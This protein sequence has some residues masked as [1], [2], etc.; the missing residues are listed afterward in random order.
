MLVEYTN[1]SNSQK[2]FLD[3]FMV[4]SQVCIKCFRGACHQY[5]INH[6]EGVRIRMNDRENTYFTC[7]E[8]DMKTQNKNHLRS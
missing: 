8:L 3:L 1:S 4:S 7:T 6:M 2:P 5:Y